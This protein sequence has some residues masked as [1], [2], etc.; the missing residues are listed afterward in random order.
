[1]CEG[2]SEGAAFCVLLF[3]PPCFAQGMPS[4]C[5]YARMYVCVY[6]CQCVREGRCLVGRRT[7]I[8]YFVILK[9]IRKRGEGEMT[10]YF[11]SIQGR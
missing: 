10:F 3:L 6:V 7:K 5:L 9:R 8:F 1:M 11:F 4:P 2:W